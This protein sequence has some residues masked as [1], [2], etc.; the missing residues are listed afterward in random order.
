MFRSMGRIAASAVPSENNTAEPAA[1]QIAAEKADTAAR[2]ADIRIAAP[3]VAWLR[4]GERAA[5]QLSLSLR[6]ERALMQ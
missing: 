4:W 3:A 5:S 6:A 1:G 2:P